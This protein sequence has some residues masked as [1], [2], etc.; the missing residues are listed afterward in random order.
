MA[1]WLHPMRKSKR[2]CLHNRLTCMS[3]YIYII[4]HTHT[5]LLRDNAGVR[6]RVYL[7]PRMAPKP[8]GKMT[9][10]TAAYSHGNA[11]SKTSEPASVVPHR[12][13]TLSNRGLFP[14]HCC[15]TW[16]NEFRDARRKHVFGEGLQDLWLGQRLSV[17]PLRPWDIG[18]SE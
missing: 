7:R 6:R 3:I 12:R 15:S 17:I 16:G 10:S 18:I 11:V 4:T 14:R 13:V 8:S 1:L 9:E 2:A 5:Q